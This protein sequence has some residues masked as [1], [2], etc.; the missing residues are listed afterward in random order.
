VNTWFSKIEIHFLFGA[1]SCPQSKRK[2]VFSRDRAYIRWVSVSRSTGDHL[3]QS[4]AVL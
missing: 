2:L 4:S 1:G 3:T